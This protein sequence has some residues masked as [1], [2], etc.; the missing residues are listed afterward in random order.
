MKATI[1]RFLDLS[2]SHLTAEQREYGGRDGDRSAWGGAVVEVH[3]YGFWLWVPDDP[4]ESS[5]ASEERV[6]RNLLA[7]QLYARRRGCDY[8]LF[9]RD[10][11]VNKDL[12]TFRDRV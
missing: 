10:A 8:V 9:D 6:P 4:K 12:R 5:R 1:R 2:T 11:E 3:E 7:V